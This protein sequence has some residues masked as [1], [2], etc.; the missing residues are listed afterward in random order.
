M[1][2]FRR[3]VF[4]IAYQHDVAVVPAEGGHAVGFAGNQQAVVHFIT[5]PRQYLVAEPCRQIE[6]AHWVRYESAEAKVAAGACMQRPRRRSCRCNDEC[7]KESPAVDQVRT[8]LL[9]T[10]S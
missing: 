9:R 6:D 2:A 1:K 5:L 7:L 4:V 10:E 3:R 8:P